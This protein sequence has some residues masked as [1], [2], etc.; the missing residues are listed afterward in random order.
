M[1][2]TRNSKVWDDVVEIGSV[3][4]SQKGNK[5][6]VE[7]KV[8]ECFHRKAHG[9]CSRGDSSRFSLDPS[10]PGN[11]GKGQRPK[12]RSSSPT[13]NSKA[14]QTDGGK[15]TKRKVLT[16]EVRLFADIENVKT[17]RFGVFPF[18]K[19]LKEDA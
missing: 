15:A 19:S 1:I 14:R 4:K 16:R 2:R 10:A 3:T 12:G 6:H 17:R 5:A 13:P 7:R 8:G 18:V 9:Q 11:S